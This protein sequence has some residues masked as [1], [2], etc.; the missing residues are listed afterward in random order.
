MNLFVGTPEWLIAILCAL[1]VAAG[2]QDFL[3]LRISNVFPLAVLVAALVAM[4]LRGWSID[5]WENFVV[6][7]ILLTLGTFLFAGGYMGGGDVKLFATVGLWTD[8]ERALLL[9]PA[10]LLTGGV[11]A[12]L[13]LS[14][15][16]LP[17]PANGAGGARKNKKVP[18]GVAIAIGTL[19]VIGLQV[20]S[21]LDSRAQLAKLSAL[22]SSSAR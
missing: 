2:V 10:V 1:V 12:L 19:I 9:L 8:F 21:R 20:Q 7:G 17:L 18:Y 3:R 5:A 6:F 11:L 16:L 14:R 15:R 13:L 4:S 22:T